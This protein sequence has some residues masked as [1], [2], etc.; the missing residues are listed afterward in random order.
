M[1]LARPWPEMQYR[2]RLA[3]LPR[4]GDDQVLLACHLHERAVM[5]FITQQAADPAGSAPDAEYHWRPEQPFAT[6][7]AT[8]RRSGRPEGD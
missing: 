8:Q 5:T 7:K 6:T 2:L 1:L 4:F 3:R